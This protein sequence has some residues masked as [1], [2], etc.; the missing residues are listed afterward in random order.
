VGKIKSIWNIILNDFSTKKIDLVMAK[1]VLEDLEIK[2][3]FLIKKVDKYYE[4]HKEVTLWDLFVLL[5]NVIEYKTYKSEL[6][7]RKKMDLI[8][9]KI[10]KYAVMSRL[11]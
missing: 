5:L 3:E 6:H 2:E 1:S 4:I 11:I 10:F 8:S 7:K 9:S